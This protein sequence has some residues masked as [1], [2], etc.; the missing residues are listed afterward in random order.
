[1]PI[2]I[3]VAPGDHRTNF[4]TVEEQFNQWKESA[5]P[6]NVIDIH[7]MVNAMPEK[8]TL[9]EFMLTMVVRYE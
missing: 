8:S 1:M 3:F 9:G 6:K 2:K 7:C 4:E 5:P